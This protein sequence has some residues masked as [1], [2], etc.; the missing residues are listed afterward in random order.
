MGAQCSTFIKDNKP[1]AG[2]FLR[3]VIPPPVVKKT[4][5]NPEIYDIIWSYTKC[6]NI[7]LWDE[8]YDS[9]EEEDI[10]RFLISNINHEYVPESYD[11]E[12]HAISLCA[13]L[14]E[15]AYKRANRKGGLLTGLLAG[16]LKFNEKDDI[17]AHAVCFFIDSSGKLKLV[18]G[19]VNEIQDFGKYMTAWTVIV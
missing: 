2:D 10:K 13:R 18:D 16:N 17:R 12:D 15:W 7:I 6:E 9:I 8:Q 3:A 11:C 4:F 5:T 19:T 1:L 14:R